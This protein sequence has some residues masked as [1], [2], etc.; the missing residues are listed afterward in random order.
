MTVTEGP[1]PTRSPGAGDGGGRV[2]AAGRVLAVLD[3]FGPAHR[4]L[5]L[6][7]ISRR[8][9]LTL[10]TT[11]RL[12]RELVAWGALE[13][14]DSGR[15]A[16]GLRLLELSALA[17]RGLGLRDAAF[18]YLEDLHQTTHGNVHLGVRDGLEVVYVEAIR[19]RVRKPVDSHV[20]DRWPM[21]ATG[22]GLVLLAHAHRELQ[23]QV[24]RSPLTRF[25]PLTVVDPAELRRR[26]AQVRRTGV[27]V[28]RG[29]ITVPDIVVAVPVLGR[30][31]E[32]AA[33]IS[34][35]VEADDARPRELAAVLAE[36]SRSIS[37]S[38]AG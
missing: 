8:A 25:S 6:S 34:V 30:R 38:L 33:A 28:A 18:P 2:T 22:T 5:T 35:V 11:H 13:R 24:L 31:G 32:V 4:T 19:A 10:P 16:V 20:G 3:A 7:A 12:V 27:A 1:R 29:Q 9:G 15:Y 26:L 17:P 37:A 36:A 14:D 21:H 23:E